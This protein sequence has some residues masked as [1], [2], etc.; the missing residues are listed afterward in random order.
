MPVRCVIASQHREEAE[1]APAGPGGIQGCF[2]EVLLATLEEDCRS[3]L[4]SSGGPFTEPVWSYYELTHPLLH[5]P[6]RLNFQGQKAALPFQSLF[7]PIRS[8]Q[9]TAWG[10]VHVVCCQLLDIFPHCLPTPRPSLIGNLGPSSEIRSFIVTC[11]LVTYLN[12][13]CRIIRGY[14]LTGAAVGT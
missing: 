4:L 10:G 14:G 2:T 13:L 3:I 12:P 1:G 8:G 11:P 7:P 9:I 6:L 5:E